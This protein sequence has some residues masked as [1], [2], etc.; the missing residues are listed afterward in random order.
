M[1]YHHRLGVIVGET[2]NGVVQDCGRREDRNDII[3][4]CPY[5]KLIRQKRHINNG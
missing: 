5:N 4:G 2:L 3:P 1:I